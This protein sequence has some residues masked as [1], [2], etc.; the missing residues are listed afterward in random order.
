M[1]VWR[2]AQ[3]DVSPDGE[4]FLMIRREPGS[5]PTQINLITHWHQE[6]ERFVP[7]K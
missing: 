2:V 5:V 6:L 1:S 3:Y 4:K 7:T